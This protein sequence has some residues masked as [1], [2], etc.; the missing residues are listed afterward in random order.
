MRCGSLHTPRAAATALL[1][2]ALLPSP[3]LVPLDAAEA[4]LLLLLAL[5]Q[6]VSTA[7]LKRSM[8][9]S[10]TSHRFAIAVGQPAFRMGQS[11]GDQGGQK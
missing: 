9:R 5:S 4:C 1:T 8:S 11:A 10:V 3:L 2:S 6:R 7:W